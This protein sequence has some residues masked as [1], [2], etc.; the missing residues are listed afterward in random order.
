MSDKN[1]SCS[2]LNWGPMKTEEEMNNIRKI[3]EYNYKEKNI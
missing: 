2:E 3:K 1:M